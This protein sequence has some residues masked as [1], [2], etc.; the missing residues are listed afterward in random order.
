MHN[1][2]KGLGGN[3]ANFPVKIREFLCQFQVVIAMIMM[4]TTLRFVV[5]KI[6]HKALCGVLNNPYQINIYVT[7][8]CYIYMQHICDIYVI[9]IVHICYIYVAYMWYICYIYVRCRNL[10]L[11]GGYM[12]N[13]CYIYVTYMIHECVSYVK[14]K[15]HICGIYVT[16][17]STYI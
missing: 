10:G 15:L 2:C 17:M 14:Y 16:Y 11:V 5:F 13:I 6:G 7:Y 1:Q 9:Y 3:L 4:T 12:L 8:N